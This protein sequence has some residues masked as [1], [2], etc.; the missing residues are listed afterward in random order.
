MNDSTI[1]DKTSERNYNLIFPNKKETRH[2]RRYDDVDD[3]ELSTKWTVDE[4][5]L[6]SFTEKKY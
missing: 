2:D 4:P 3:G 5:F 6:V 1:D